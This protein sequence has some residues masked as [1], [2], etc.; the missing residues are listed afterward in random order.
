MPPLFQGTAFR[1]E[2]SPV[3]NLKPTTP[4]PADAETGRLDLLAKLN[5]DHKSRHPGELDLDALGRWLDT[6]MLLNCS[7]ESPLFKCTI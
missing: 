1:S 6:E 7:V 5:Q 3:L 4:R 2:G